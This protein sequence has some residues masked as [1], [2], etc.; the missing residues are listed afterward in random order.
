MNYQIDDQKNYNEKKNLQEIIQEHIVVMNNESE[1]RFE[2][3][4]ADEEE[5]ED[6]V[7]IEYNLAE[8]MMNSSSGGPSQCGS[9][10]NPISTFA[11][12]SKNQRS[13]AFD[14]VAGN[15]AFL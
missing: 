12:A 2:I 6:S 7:A 5:E 1:A 8:I 10:S 4:S 13:Q 14:S 15:L 3:S 9:H 11:A